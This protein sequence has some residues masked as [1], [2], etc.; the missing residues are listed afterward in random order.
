M[1]IQNEVE[2][3]FQSRIEALSKDKDFLSAKDVAT[4]LNVSDRTIR[5]R[6]GMGQL[7]A[8]KIGKIWC[9]RKQDIIEYIRV[10]LRKEY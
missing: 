7:P 10:N 4:L 9:I 8:F 6:I 2:A 3:I 5:L 1:N